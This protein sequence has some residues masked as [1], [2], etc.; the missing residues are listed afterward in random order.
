MLNLF[1]RI[2]IDE[3]FVRNFSK[4]ILGT[5]SLHL[6]NI[7]TVPI[8]TRL[9]AVEA[10]GTQV[11]YLSIVGIFV[12][13]ATGKYE[14]AILLPE[15]DRESFLICCFTIM[16]SAVVSVLGWIVYAVFK[17]KLFFLHGSIE[18]FFWLQ[19]LPITVFA[20]TLFLVCTIYLN[21]MRDY[22][23]MA[24]SGVLVSIFN[25]IISFSYALLWPND[26]FGLCLYTFV[27]NLSVGILLIWYGYLKKYFYWKWISLKGM[28]SVAKYYINMPRYMICGGI[29][30]ELSSRLPVFFLQSFADEIVVGWYAM[31]IKLLGLPIQLITQSV[32]NVFMRDA[33][34]EWNEKRSCW[35]SFKKTFLILILIGVIS[36]LALYLY[37]IDICTICLGGRWYMAGVYCVYLLPMYFMKFIFSPLSNVLIITNRQKMFLYLQLCRICIV[38]SSLKIGYIFFETVDAVI[39]SFGAGFS[40]YYIVSLIYCGKV[41]Y[42]NYSRT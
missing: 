2:H 13:F 6:I 14:N 21:R 16:L 1:E 10:Y 25:F 11:Y 28:F 3:I 39:F 4:L 27:G 37:V 35:L 26:R 23:M 17:E 7:L 36:F 38:A 20:I 33:V 9:Y 24:K 31:S 40:I 15:D 18:I 34:D 29:L 32:G 42:K 22:G 41:S 8:L 19:W 12:V 5:G 30:N